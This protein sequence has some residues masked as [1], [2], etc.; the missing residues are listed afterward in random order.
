MR[1]LFIDKGIQ[2]FKEHFKIDIN[3]KKNLTV[4]LRVL[5]EQ[6]VRRSKYINL[7]PRTDLQTVVSK[8]C[9]VKIW[10]LMVGAV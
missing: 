1:K 9:L 2:F 6:N 4:V 5:E 8:P 3:R 10:P 7:L